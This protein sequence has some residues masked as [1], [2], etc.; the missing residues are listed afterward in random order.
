MTRDIKETRRA[1]KRFFNG[2]E[3]K[4]WPQSRGA[5]WFPPPAPEDV[6]GA[7]RGDPARCVLA[8]EGRRVLGTLSRGAVFYRSVAWVHMPQYGNIA[9]RLRLYGDTSRALEGFDSTGDMVV[10]AEGITLHPPTKSQTL[11]YKR[12]RRHEVPGTKKKRGRSTD[13]LGWVR[14]TAAYEPPIDEEG[15]QA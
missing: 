10:L 3:R 5:I 4:D 8:N 11:A 13:P 9:W 1:L 6:V 12:T 7:V 14:G 2:L 15:D